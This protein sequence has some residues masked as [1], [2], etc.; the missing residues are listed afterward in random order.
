MTS[1]SRWI[2]GL[3]LCASLGVAGAQEAYRTYR[4]ARFGY[5]VRYP[6]F[7]TMDP[8]PENG[9]G[10]MFHSSDGNIQLM[11]WG[12]LNALDET[13][14][15]RFEARLQAAEDA[16]QKVT[17]RLLTDTYYE[18]ATTRGRELVY[19]RCA[20]S[21]EERAADTAPQAFSALLFRYDTV[22]QARMVKIIETVGPSLTGPSGE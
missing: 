22:H 12:S 9:D 3:L 11:V 10:R 19:E 14:Q 1:L 18:Y 17:R 2:A 20:V 8:P 13:L 4:N 21:R 16:G 5:E 7:L 6:A 15:Q